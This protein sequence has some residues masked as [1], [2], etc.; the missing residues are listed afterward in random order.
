MIREHLI[1]ALKVALAVASLSAVVSLPVRELAPQVSWLELV[2]SV[3]CVLVFVTV[4]AVATLV[5]NQAVLRAG[6]TDPQ[7]L[8]FP[9]DP[10]GLE[11][12]RHEAREL[13]R[14]ES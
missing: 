13:E 1:I 10:P 9:A 3:L 14:R 8:A 4:V 7:W 11:N 2:G 6:G 5:I 12:L